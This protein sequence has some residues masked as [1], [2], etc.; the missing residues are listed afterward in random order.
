LKIFLTSL[1]LALP[2]FVFANAGSPIIW[3]NIFHLLFINAIIG[4]VESEI[5]SKYKLPNKTWL[6]LI[7]NYVSMIV[8]YFVIIPN[9]IKPQ[10]GRDIWSENP[11]D[12]ALGFFISFV[13]TLLIEYPFFTASLKDK[14]QRKK[15]FKP[16]LVANVVT[17]ISMISIYYLFITSTP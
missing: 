12:L 11:N 7:A 17:N 16:F 1:F 9:L 15:L 4:Y 2:I 8:G 6:V 14:N 10:Y 3:F 5:L 13:V